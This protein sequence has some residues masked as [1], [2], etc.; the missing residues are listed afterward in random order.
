MPELHHNP[1]FLFDIKKYYLYRAE[2]KLRARDHIWSNKPMNGI[3]FPHD[4]E[5][6]VEEDREEKNVR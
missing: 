6:K 3:Q 5:E 4:K 2:D 1:I